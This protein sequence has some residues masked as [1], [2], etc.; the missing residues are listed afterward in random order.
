MEAVA[1]SASSAQGCLPV[2]DGTGIV[3]QFRDLR[4]KF[5]LYV[6]WLRR[7]VVLTRNPTREVVKSVATTNVC[8]Y[9]SPAC[10]ARES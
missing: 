6:K 8:L 1:L 2:G 3:P 4:D 5:T 9:C 10:Q 7:N